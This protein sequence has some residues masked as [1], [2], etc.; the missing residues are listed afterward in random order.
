MSSKPDGTDPRVL[1]PEGETVYTTTSVSQSKTTKYHTQDCYSLEQ[2]DGGIREIDMSVAK[3]KDMKPCDYCQTEGEN[4]HTPVI[5]GNEVHRI[6][7]ALANGYN[8][9][10]VAAGHG[11]NIST[12]RYH[13][14]AT[15]DYN[16]SVEPTLPTVEFDQ[17][18]QEWVWS[19]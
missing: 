18:A 13:A 12:I 9:R 4:Q 14:K 16:Y 10:E 17:S 6:R 2:K 5:E 15:R 7:R 1:Q 19:E 3:W 11:F 8:G